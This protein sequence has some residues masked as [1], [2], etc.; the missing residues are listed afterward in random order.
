M[1]KKMDLSGQKYGRLLVISESAKRDRDGNIYWNCLCDCGSEIVARGRSL[2]DT[3]IQKSTRSCGCL[4]KDT[5]ADQ[6]QNR[7]AEIIGKRFGFLIVESLAWVK[8]E[9]GAYYHCICDCGRKSV[10]R[11]NSLQQGVTK[12]CGCLNLKTENRRDDISGGISGLL[13]ATE[14]SHTE[15][16]LGVATAFWR[17]RCACGNDVVIPARY[18]AHRMALSCGCHKVPPMSQAQKKIR[19]RISSRM[20]DSLIS[21]KGGRGWESLVGYELA[22]LMAHM[23]KQFLPGMSWENMG[24]WHIDHIVPVSA[25]NYQSYAE[26]DFMDCWAL[27]NLRPIWAHENL[28]KHAKRTHLL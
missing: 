25:F 20:R 3:N 9:S 21:G 8:R 10:V 26:K 27:S 24:K 16:R 19:S 12:S 28:V 2:R 17:C 1:P 14:Y 22:D 18:I 13:S 4:K 7:S 23:E 6:M 15:K 5:F 11:W